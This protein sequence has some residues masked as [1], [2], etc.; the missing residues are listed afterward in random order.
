MLVYYHMKICILLRQVDWTIFEGVITP[1]D[2]EYVIK[3]NWRGHLFYV[4][5]IVFALLYFR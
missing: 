5:K 1:F 3:K 2:L 4:S